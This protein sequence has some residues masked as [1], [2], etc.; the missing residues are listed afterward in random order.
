MIFE[1]SKNFCIGARFFLQS[2]PYDRFENNQSQRCLKFEINQLRSFLPYLHSQFIE[3]DRVRS[4]RVIQGPLFQKFDGD[5]IRIYHDDRLSETLQVNQTAFNYRSC[6]TEADGIRESTHQ[7]RLPT[8]AQPPRSRSPSYQKHFRWLGTLS[9]R[10][11]VTY[12]RV[13]V[14]VWIAEWRTVAQHNPLPREVL[15]L[16]A[17]WGW[18]VVGH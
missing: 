18:T 5:V 12:F 10:A 3:H 16:E 7:R 8:F 4:V 1:S 14:T 9:D 15:Q 6:E 13:G 11:G 2:S 17:W